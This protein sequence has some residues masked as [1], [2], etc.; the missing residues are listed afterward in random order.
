M[1]SGCSPQDLPENF[2]DFLVMQFVKMILLFVLC[3]YFVKSR[4]VLHH[5]LSQCE[6]RLIHADSNPCMYLYLHLMEFNA[7]FRIA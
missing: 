7:L 1:S 5:N 6:S 3:V 2:I 4:M